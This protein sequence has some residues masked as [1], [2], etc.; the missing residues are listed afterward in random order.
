MNT[1]EKKSRKNYPGDIREVGTKDYGL[2]LGNLINYRNQLIREDEEQTI[3]ELFL[4][5]AEKL[6]EIGQQKAS[7]LVKRKAGRRK[8]GMFQG[9][10]AKKKQEVCDLAVR[11]WQEGKEK[12]ENAKQLRKELAKISDEMN[13]AISLHEKQKEKQLSLA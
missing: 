7:A 12:H 11:C 9:I 10:N 13:S 8:Q 4:K 5:I 3:G 2:I 6:R 1:R